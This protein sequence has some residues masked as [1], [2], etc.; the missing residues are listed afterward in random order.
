MVYTTHT[1]SGIQT[2]ASTTAPQVPPALRPMY[3]GNYSSEAGL[4]QPYFRRDI[5][6]LF[7]LPEPRPSQHGES[8][9]TMPV[10]TANDYQTPVLQQQTPGDPSLLDGVRELMAP[11]PTATREPIEV[12]REPIMAA[13]QLPDTIGAPQVVPDTDMHLG[14]VRSRTAPVNDGATALRDRRL[15]EYEARLNNS[16]AR[17]TATTEIGDERSDPMAATGS[18]ILRGAGHGYLLQPPVCQPTQTSR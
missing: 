16:Q 11:R 17:P 5:T 18:G 3:F 2:N 9:G 14:D 12:Q 10:A 4:S 7:G 15:A 6:N 13:R 1:A 8:I